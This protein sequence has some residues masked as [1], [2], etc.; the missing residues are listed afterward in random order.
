MCIKGAKCAALQTASAKNIESAT[1]AAAIDISI[2]H[3]IIPSSVFCYLFI[4]PA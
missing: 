4:T 2:G 1:A 3:T